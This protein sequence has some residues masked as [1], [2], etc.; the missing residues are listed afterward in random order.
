MFK[1]F[2][3]V[4]LAAGGPPI[5]SS[6]SA[7]DYATLEACQA[8]MTADANDPKSLAAFKHSAEEAIG[9]EVKLAAV[10]AEVT[11]EGYAVD[12]DKLK[13]DLGL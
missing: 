3:V 12:E 1:I 8:E 4:F 13:S 11:Q 2:V 5:A 6:R 7:T 9:Q 10:C